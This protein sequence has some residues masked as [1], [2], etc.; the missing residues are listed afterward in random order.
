MKLILICLLGVIIYQS[1]DARVV[2][3]DGLQF[4]SDVIEPNPQF[5]NPF[6]R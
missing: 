1:N 2:I 6:T 4:A 3:S 5:K